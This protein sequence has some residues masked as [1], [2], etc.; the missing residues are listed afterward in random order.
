[1]KS[2]ARMIQEIFKMLK[3][4]RSGQ[5]HVASQPV[6]FPPHPLSGGMLSRSIGK[7]SR[8][9]GRQFFGTRMVFRE[10]F[11]LIQQRLLQ[12]LIRRN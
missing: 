5:S 1:M 10:T 6:F 7:P 8:K 3:S 4:V 9:M 11:L 2:I 12:H